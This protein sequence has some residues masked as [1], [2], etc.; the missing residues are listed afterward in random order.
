MKPEDTMMTITLTLTRDGTLHT[1]SSCSPKIIPEMRAHLALGS[2]QRAI[3]IFGE[4]VEV[5]DTP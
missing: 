4:E 2:L 3:S 5:K 1:Q